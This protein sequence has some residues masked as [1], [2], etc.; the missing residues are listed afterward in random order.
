MPVSLRR[1][2]EE[3][4]QAPLEKDPR[5]DIYDIVVRMVIGLLINFVARKLRSRGELARD[6]K[7]AARKVEKL[8]KKGKEIPEKLEEKATA[9]LSRAQKKKL[10]K[11]A[12]KEKGKAAKAKKAKKSKRKGKLLM[13]VAAIAAIALVAR[14]VTRK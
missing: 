8:R 3:Q 7:E 11:A 14:A 6:R 1:N 12:E 5:K 4:P 2:A 10:A 9:G 13:L